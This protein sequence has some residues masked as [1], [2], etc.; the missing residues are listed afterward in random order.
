MTLYTGDVPSRPSS[1]PL[2]RAFALASALATAA[3]GPSTPGPAKKPSASRT[4][5]DL[6]AAREL[7]QEGVRAFTD[8]RFRTAMD[9]FDAAARLGGPASELWNMAKCQQKLE[10]MEGAAST[11][12]KY[13]SR[14]DLTAEDR[15]EA[16]RELAEIR[17]RPSRVTVLT[18]PAG[19]TVVVDDKR[20][21]VMGK[22]PTTFDL[23]PGDHVLR[24][25]MP[26]HAPSSKSVTTGLGRP[27]IVELSLSKS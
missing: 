7:D 6:A 16:N 24:V 17:R 11:I 18:T 22:S 20:Q 21:T 13:L 1:V 15:A 5:P 26:G 8:G 4:S 9:Y 2:V 3:C 27:V 14:K 25:E 19:A 12:E 10:D 23:P